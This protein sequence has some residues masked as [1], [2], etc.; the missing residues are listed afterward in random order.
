MI[1][2]DEIC[3]VH[4]KE[5]DNSDKVRKVSKYNLETGAE[6]DTAKLWTS[7]N[8]IVSISLAGRPC[9]AVSY[10]MYNGFTS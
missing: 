3:V 8:G 2:D 6:L 1:N 9:V 5:K 4:T 7:P 10:H